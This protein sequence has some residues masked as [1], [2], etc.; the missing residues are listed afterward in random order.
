MRALFQ[1]FDLY[2]KPRLYWALALL[3]VLFVLSYPFPKIF[4]IAQI[5]LLAMGFVLA[6]DILLVLLFKAPISAVRF[7]TE[8]WSLSDENKVRIVLKNNGYFNWKIEVIDELPEQLQI[9]NF[10]KKISIAAKAVK[11]LNYHV[12]PMKRGQFQFNYIQVF[13]S[14][15]LGLVSRRLRCGEPQMIPVYPSILQMK[16]YALYTVSH[17]AR[18]Y[19][20]KRMRRIGHSYEFEQIKDYVRGDDMRHINW[21]ATSKTGILKTNHFIEER[22]QPVYCIIDKSRN[23]NMAFEGMTLLDYAINASLVI[24]NTALQKGDKA[25]LITFSDKVGTAIRADNNPTSLRNIMENLYAQKYRQTE[26]DYE[27]LFNAIGRVVSNRSLLFLFA[28]F[29]TVSSL[30]RIL[31]VLRKIN[32]RHLLVL[33]LFQNA[34]LESFA[35]ADSNSLKEVYH[36]TIARQMLDNKRQMISTLRKHG[37]QSVLTQ[38]Q[39]LTIN[40]LNK[41]I[42]LKAKGLV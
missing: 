27:F 26:P 35:Y 13:I 10:S 31:P 18:Y 42:E 36:R 4:S 33:I 1:R 21:K 41:Y 24:S 37:I 16:K 40:T 3:F 12:K 38:P 2:T 14:S 19:G 20:V 22:A 28:N 23:M 32:Q 15:P 11:E 25:G 17:L 29:E 34:E 30:E 8:K 5:I 9:R 6:V 7:V 39:D